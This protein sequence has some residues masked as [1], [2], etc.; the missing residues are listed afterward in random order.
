MCVVCVVSRELSERLAHFFYFAFNLVYNLS[1]VFVR[2]LNC[3]EAAMC[4]ALQSGAQKQGLS[5]WGS[6]AAVVVPVLPDRP[7]GLTVVWL[8]V[9]RNCVTVFRGYL[10]R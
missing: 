1:A 7:F 10:H 4:C 6:V 9:Q 2:Q 8:V 3:A 5:Y